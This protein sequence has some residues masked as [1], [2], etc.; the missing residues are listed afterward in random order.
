MRSASGAR[1]PAY[2]LA[3]SAAVQAGRIP[4][5]SAAAARAPSKAAVVAATRSIA[6]SLIRK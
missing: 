6:A 1:A 4:R 2:H 5:R 3:H